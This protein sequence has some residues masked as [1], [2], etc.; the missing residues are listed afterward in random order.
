[1]EDKTFCTLKKVSAYR[2]RYNSEMAFDDFVDIYGAPPDPPRLTSPIFKS[3][4]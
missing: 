3:D 2:K 1:M 4:P